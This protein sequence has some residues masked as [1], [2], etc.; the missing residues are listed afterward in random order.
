MWFGE[1][2]WDWNTLYYDLTV[3]QRRFW[4]KKMNRILEAREEQRNNN[5][6]DAK[7]KK[8]PTIVKGPF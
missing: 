6:P 8:P 4:T 7:N 1:G 3:P 2:R 5:N